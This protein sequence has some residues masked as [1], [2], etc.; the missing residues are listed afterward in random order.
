MEILAI[1]DAERLK[2]E[3]GASMRKAV[4]SHSQAGAVRYLVDR[5]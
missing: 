3:E 5:A 4:I 2:E 1:Y